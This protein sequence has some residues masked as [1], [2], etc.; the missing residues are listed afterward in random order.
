VKN[1]QVTMPPRFQP[2]KEKAVSKGSTS[3]E[4]ARDRIE[5]ALRQVLIE[6]L[7]DRQSRASLQ[8]SLIGLHA[9]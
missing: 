8:V 3:T 5:S 9:G 7:P 6:W 1:G 4:E 2:I